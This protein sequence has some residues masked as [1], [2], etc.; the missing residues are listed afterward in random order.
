MD[1]QLFDKFNYMF[2]AILLVFGAG[3]VMEV[4]GQMFQPKSN[5]S[6]VTE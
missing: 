4:F 5:I 6:N 3:I 1:K 2:F